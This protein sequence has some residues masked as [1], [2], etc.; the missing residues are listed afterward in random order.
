MCAW[1]CSVMC[2]YVDA[3]LE[4]L[5]TICGENHSCI[6]QTN[7]NTG[8]RENNHLWHRRDVLADMRRHKFLADKREQARLPLRPKVD[9]TWAQRMQMHTASLCLRSVCN[10]FP[11]Q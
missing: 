2:R 9:V 3:S 6:L 5:E 4:F 11:A 10:L 1:R 8:G 7:R